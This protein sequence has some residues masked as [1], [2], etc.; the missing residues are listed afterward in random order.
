MDIIPATIKAL[1]QKHPVHVSHASDGGRPH[2]FSDNH[3][4]CSCMKD[5]CKIN[6]TNFPLYMFSDVKHNCGKVHLE[7]M[8]EFKHLLSRGYSVYTN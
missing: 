8:P 3:Y 2:F 4:V 5:K 7:T 1:K 6:A